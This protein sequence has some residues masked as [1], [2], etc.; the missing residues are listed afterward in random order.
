MSKKETENKYYYDE[1]EGQKKNE[2]IYIVPFKKFFLKIFKGETYYLLDRYRYD[3]NTMM[4]LLDLNRINKLNDFYKDYPDGIEKVIFIEFLKKH[5]PCDY[6]DPMDE[7]NLVYGLYKLFCEVDFNGDGHMQWEEFTQFIIDTV[8]GD[9]DAKVDQSEDKNAKLFDEKAMIKYK[10]YCISEKLNDNLT[11]KND[12]MNG[13]FLSK[14]DVIIFTEYGQKYIKLYSPKTGKNMGSI[15]IND[16][17]NEFKGT[18]NTRGNKRSSGGQKKNNKGVT[19]LMS[20][21]NVGFSILYLTHYQNVIALCLSDKRILFFYYTSHERIELI[22]EV[23]VPTLEKRI[24]YL[25]EHKIWVCSG[26]KLEKYSYFTLNQ[27]DIDIKFKSKKFEYKLNKTHPYSRHFCDKIPH[28]GEIL[29]VIEIS[30][31]KMVVTACMDGKIRLM[32]VSD[33]D[34]VKIWNQHTLGVRSLDYNPLIDN[35]GY[36]LSVGFEYYI[37]VYCT[38]LSIDEAFKGRLDGH[39]APVISCKFLSQSY[40][41]VS[42]DEEGNVRIW[43]TRAKLCLQTIETPKKN[44]VISGILCLSKYNKF[45]VYGNKIIYYDAKY[46]EEDHIVSSENVDENYPIKVEFNK[47]YQ[48]FFV[49]SFRDVSVYN[50]DGNLFKVYSKLIRNEHFESEVKIKSFIFDD[51]YRKFYIG[52]S[53]GA[54]LLFNAGNGSL[55]K[56]I[57]ETEVEKDGIQFFTYSHTKEVTSMYYY[58][59]E[60]NNNENLILL[61]VSHDSL[62]N[63][64]NETNSEESEKLRSIK[65]GHTLKGKSLEIYCLDFSKQLAFFATGSSDSL[66]VVWNFELSK[67]EDILYLQNNNKN[68]KLN[69]YTVKFL[70]PYPLIACGY[71]DGQFLIWGVKEANIRGQ[72][73]FRARNY[74]RVPKKKIEPVSIRCINTIQCEEGEGDVTRHLELMKYFDEQSPFMNPD[75]PYTPPKIKIK[76]EKK[77]EH[78]KNQNEETYIIDEE[79]NLDI[80]P[81]KYKNEIIDKDLNPDNYDL[82]VVANDNAFVQRYY[83]I[84]GDINGNVKIMNILGL[85]KKYKLNPASKVHIKSSF[86]ILKRDDVNVETILIHNIVPMTDK[87]LPKFTNLYINNVLVK[88]FKAHNDEINS[89]TVLLEPICFT[90]CSKDKLV[91]IWNLNNECLGV[92]SPYVKLDMNDKTIQKWNFRVDEEKLLEDEINEVV[93]IFEKVGARRI[94]R[95]SKEDREVENIKIDDRDNKLNK[96]DGRKMTVLL[97]AEKREGKNKKQESNKNNNDY[98][99]EDNAYGEGYEDYYGED[100]EEQ[101][102]GMINNENVQKTGMNQMTIDAIKNMVKA[103]KK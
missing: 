53:N 26:S 91:K 86:N 42:V 4:S 47:Y 64:Y 43:D 11:H 1:D 80:I 61:S 35:A 102:E 76:D 89:I 3:V 87:K 39:S 48:Q 31:P 38:D 65:G 99:N 45:V 72:C 71:S 55:I 54:I 18:E 94:T 97:L 73:L 79:N 95:G 9:K 57:N 52:F 17:L 50:K 66:V 96:G 16:V 40:M 81:E 34:V 13:V 2:K 62:I 12:V 32:D 67:I 60:D 20:Q 7:T 21:K 44:F 82:S 5:L 78:K 93:D 23:H 101:I 70:D 84:L 14:S 59:D 19:N 46:R 37:N 33:R 36:V 28:K 56:P 103:K 30:K 98:F 25:P 15:D 27:L 58:N 77:K 8:E 63:V 41:A 90:T 69:V 10:R 29:D 6:N 74:S 92:I 24:W 100:K 88:E 22:Y 49:T 75:K 51:N 85:I 83:I 68:E